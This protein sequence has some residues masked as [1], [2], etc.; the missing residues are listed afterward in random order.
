MCKLPRNIKLDI[1]RQMPAVKWDVM[2]LMDVFKR[3]L[4]ARE[5]CGKFENLSV[6]ENEGY[7]TLHTTTWKEL[8]CTYCSKDHTSNRCNIITDIAARK[9]FLRE[10]NRRYNCL[11]SG[12]TV[13]TCFSKYVCFHCK[14]KHQGFCDASRWAYAA[15]VHVVT[16]AD[17]QR[18]CFFLQ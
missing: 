1:S 2:K 12:H 17:N 7:S 13:S 8:F 5:R 18:P 9:T 6:N 14:G 4:V 15:V 11:R 3:E 16:E 10:N